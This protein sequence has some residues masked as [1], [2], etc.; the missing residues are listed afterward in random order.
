MTMKTMQLALA[1]VAVLGAGAMFAQEMG[2]APAAAAPATAPVA[3]PSES[4]QV[5]PALPADDGQKIVV[6]AQAEKKQAVASE[7]KEAEV[8][9]AT[10]IVQNLL[11]GLDEAGKPV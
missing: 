11:A 8:P 7:A 4:E 3:A 1:A 2:A 10:T 5:K 9:T 6:E